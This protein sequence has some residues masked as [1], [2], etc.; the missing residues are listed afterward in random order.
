[1]ESPLPYSE[2]GL[3]RAE[4]YMMV[5]DALKEEGWVLIRELPNGRKEK[6][7][8]AETNF[9]HKFNSIPAHWRLKL[10]KHSSLKE[11]KRIK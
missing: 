4:A 10:Q 5:Y 7:T 2:K 11:P 3:S 8:V 6:F 1:M 9:R